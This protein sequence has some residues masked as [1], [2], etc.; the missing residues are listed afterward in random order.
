MK[1]EGYRMTG[2]RSTQERLDQILSVQQA[3]WLGSYLG[4]KRIIELEQAIDRGAT[5]EPGARKYCRDL[6]AVVFN[7]EVF[8][9]TEE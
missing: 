4:I 2:D 9:L 7:T 5:V 1:R 6:A 3:A 8:G